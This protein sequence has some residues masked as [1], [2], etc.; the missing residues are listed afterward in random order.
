MAKNKPRNAANAA[1]GGTATDT[2]SAK[3]SAYGRTVAN[4]P[5]GIPKKK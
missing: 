5:Y 2:N 4:G 3:T 1:A